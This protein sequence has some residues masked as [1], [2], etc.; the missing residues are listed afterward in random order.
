MSS[1]PNV[2][3]FQP[4]L[5]ELRALLDSLGLIEKLGIY[6]FTSKDLDLTTQVEF[7]PG[8]EEDVSFRP[9]SSRKDHSGRLAQH[10][11]HLAPASASVMV[12]GSMVDLVA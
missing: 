8:H 4:L 5:S 3:D 2:S 10:L 9:R 12:S 1:R 7:I 6:V 11:S